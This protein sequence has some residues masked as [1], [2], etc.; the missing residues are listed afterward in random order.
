[1]SDTPPAE[2]G[3]AADPAE[4]PESV[5]GV[6]SEPHPPEPAS[7]EP[8][9]ATA[10]AED[11]ALPASAGGFS[12]LS[13][14]PGASA[15]EAVL[16]AA[17]APN[18]P[19]W[20]PAQAEAGT[21]AMSADSPAE[22]APWSPTQ[23]DALEQDTFGQESGVEP[24][25]SFWPWGMHGLVETV[26]VL[27]L[28]LL[29]FLLVRSVAQNFVVDGGSMEPTF[30]NGEM[31]IVNKLAYRNF[32]LSWLP[33]TD[34]DNWRP[35][36]TPQSGDVVVF[37][38]PQDQNRDFIKRVIAIPGQ[39]VEVRGGKVYLNGIQQNEP[40]LDQAPTYDYGPVTVPEGQI[41]V[42]GDNRNNSYDS[43]SWGL[44]D[45]S[46]LIGRAEFRYWPMGRIGRIDHGGLSAES[47]VTITQGATSS[48]STAR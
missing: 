42:L 35:F 3:S 41:F 43:H 27:A 28:A 24:P 40:Y 20:S 14:Y 4:E 15:A 5:H 26:E 32:N 34:K 11:R 10:G 19:P 7:P 23:A 48:S 29:M 17:P 47:G 22:R 2:T 8:S 45:Q 12:S 1:M 25:S 37:K 44:L 16:P 18:R 36:G 31:L 46:L 6:S 9:S 21:V 38:F 13:R 39:T 33:F 30:H